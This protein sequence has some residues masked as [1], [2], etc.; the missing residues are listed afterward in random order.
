[1]AKILVVYGTAYGQT[2]RIARR[3]ADHLGSQGHGVCLHQGDNLPANLPLDEYDAFVVAAS[4]IRGRHQRYIRNFARHH[5]PTLTA[6]PS[7]FVSV[8]G[9]AYGSPLQADRYVEAFLDQTGWQPLFTVSFAGAVAYTH[10]GPLRRW[11]MKRAC[12]RRGGPTDTTR[13]HDLT[14]WEAVDRFVR[15]LGEALPPPAGKDFFAAG[16]TPDHVHSPRMA[17]NHERV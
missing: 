6:A 16:S 15:R 9:A 13:D 8:S 3:I 12:Q 4:V 17:P 7:A 1:M 2:E 5:A 11:I 10:Y 14:D